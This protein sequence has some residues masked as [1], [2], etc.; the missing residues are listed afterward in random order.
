MKPLL[1]SMAGDRVLQ[2]AVAL[3]DT[4]YAQVVI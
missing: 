1:V 4:F 2:D 3:S